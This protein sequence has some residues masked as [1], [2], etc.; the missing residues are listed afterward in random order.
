MG[1]TPEDA[2]EAGLSAVQPGRSQTGK[3]RFPPP[4]YVCPSEP[5]RR[6]CCN[7]AACAG[8]SGGEAQG[9]GQECL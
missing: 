9:P 1:I 8:R 2:V 4:T 6:S 7:A 3:V 5:E